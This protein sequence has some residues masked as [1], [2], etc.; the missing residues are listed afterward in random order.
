M[1][2]AVFSIDT[3]F[4]S[5]TCYVGTEPEYHIYPENATAETAVWWTFLNSSNAPLRSAFVLRGLKNVTVDLQGAKLV[6]HGRIQPFAVHDCENVT[7]RNFSIDY[8]RPFYTQGTVREAEGDGVVIEVPERFPYRVEGHDLIVYGDYWEHRLVTGDML[9]RCFD[10]ETGRPSD[11]SPLILG[12]VGDEIT[13]RP[14]PPC[15]IYHLY[16]E[17]LGERRLRLFGF[18][19]KF[20]PR[21]GN[22]LAMTHED[23]RKTGFLL[24]RCRDTVFEHVRLIHVG[25]MG[26][27]ANLCHNIT[28]NDFSMYLD[29]QPSDRIVSV[30]ADAFHTFHASGLIKVENCRFENMLDDALNVHGNYL[31]CVEQRNDRTLLVQNRSAGLLAMEY[32]QPGDEI[33]VYKGNT[34]EVRCRGTVASAVYAPGQSRN[35]T[36][37]LQEPLSGTVCE[38]D[39]LENRRTPEIEVRNCH[40]KCMGGFRISSDKRVLIEDCIFETS[41][42]AIAFTGDMNYWYE[43]TGVKDVTVRRCRFEHCGAPLL[44]ACGFQ[45]TEAA[46]FYHENITFEDNVITDPMGAAVQLSDINR[47][48]YRRNTVTGVPEGVEPV[49][50]T[51]CRHTVVE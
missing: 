28:L 25:A 15:P 37:I 11:H 23:R 48:T 31:V 49:V 51:R 2:Q 19:E 4:E 40:M 46:P 8:D 47:F 50:L 6:F 43:N 7:F 30:N 5:D 39:C 12:L 45:P 33:V 1:K 41:G 3:V 18:P 44:S 34:Q 10:A 32:L 27:T 20:R 9:F 26:V 17:D 14:N 16:A 38:G 35:M 29:E 21:V 36:V 13:P 24:E 42:F 22:I